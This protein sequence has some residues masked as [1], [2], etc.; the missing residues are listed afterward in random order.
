ME[1]LLKFMGFIGDLK[2]VRRTGWVLR[3]VKEPESVADHMYRM[4][5]LSFLVEPSSGL[6]K[7]RCIKISLVHDLAECIVGNLTPQDDILKSEKRKQEMEAM[8][9]ICSLVPEEVGNELYELWEDYE[10]QRSAEAM[11]VKDL[12]K[13]EMILQAHEYEK[14]SNSPGK[15]QEFFDSTKGKFK[16]EQVKEWVEKLNTE[17]SS[18][19]GT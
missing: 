18:S 5:I 4:A 13:F 14:L 11:F 8:K 9:H 6:N 19:S 16:T 2:Q 10:F 17:R 7:D 12:D 1:K 3:K 15:L